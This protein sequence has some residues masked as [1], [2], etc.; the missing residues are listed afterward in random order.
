MSISSKAH[1]K[2]KGYEDA[3]DAIA[4][5]TEELREH[6][7]RSP[8]VAV[9]ITAEHFVDSA[10]SGEA[11]PDDVVSGQE[12]LD[13]ARRNFALRRDML[14]RARKALFHQQVEAVQDH[15][16][17][18][19]VFLHNEL[20]KVVAKVGKCSSAMK[21]A[22]DAASVLERDD[23]EERRAWH[24][25]AKLVAT[26][27]ELRGVQLSIVRACV[28][29]GDIH[30]LYEV[31][32]I[33]NSLDHSEFWQKKRSESYTTRARDGQ[34]GHVGNYNK[35][36]DEYPRA[37]YPYKANVMPVASDQEKAYL[38][39]VCTELDLWVPTVGQLLTSWEA[40]HLAVQPVDSWSISATED[41]RDKY[42][43]ITEST[44]TT[45]FTRSTSGRKAQPPAQKKPSFGDAARRALMS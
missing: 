17:A 14:D 9:V 39:H 8:K 7:K 42:Y 27:K 10:M 28:E 44:P 6:Q 43:K 16:D 18:A 35:W 25:L 38:I 19:L 20:Q 24:D 33:R 13:R 11:F 26:Y 12:S 31:G 37:M 5:V 32:L 30:K 4:R 15:S 1:A 23:P 2:I 40:A 41:A 34:D 3:S 36:L 29:S 45:E 22:L 21:G